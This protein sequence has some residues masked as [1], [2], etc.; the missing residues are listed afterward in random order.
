VL[1]FLKEKELIR[2]DED[3]MLRVCA[4]AKV[5]A[6]Q[7]RLY[8]YEN[9]SVRGAMPVP[10]NFN[11]PY[12]QVQELIQLYMRQQTEKDPP[13]RTDLKRQPFSELPDVLPQFT[14]S[15]VLKIDTYEREIHKTRNTGNLGFER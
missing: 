1:A 5:K 10:I 13:L 2:I 9:R 15:Q 3:D 7:R 12:Q 14:S 4:W 8:A 11:G 6:P